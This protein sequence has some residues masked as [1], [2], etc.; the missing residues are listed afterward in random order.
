MRLLESIHLILSW[1]RLF[2]GRNWDLIN[3]WK[4]FV[5]TVIGL[6]FDHLGTFCKW[7]MT[8][9][10]TLGRGDRTFR[11]SRGGGEAWFGRNGISID[12]TTCRSYFCIIL[13]TVKIFNREGH[14][15]WKKYIEGWGEKE[16]K[17]EHRRTR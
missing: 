6:G 1:R 16:H 3:K 17:K 4:L 7:T 8:L 15:S 14:L 12:D 2:I 13:W 5:V 10:A 11:V 9:K